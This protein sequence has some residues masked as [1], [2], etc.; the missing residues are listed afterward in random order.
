MDYGKLNAQKTIK[1][2]FPL[3]FTDIMQ[4]QAI[5]Q[6]TYSFMNGYRGYNQLA[7]TLEDSENATFISEWGAFMYLVMPFGMCNASST[8]QH[9]IM[10]S[11]LN[12]LYKFLTIFVDDFIVYGEEKHHI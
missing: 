10:V 12:F 3:P 2:T 7:I 1:D 9:C 4:D 11:F 8:F 5:G 6:E